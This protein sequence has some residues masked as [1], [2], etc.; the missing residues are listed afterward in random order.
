MPNS[1]RLKDWRKV[2][3]NFYIDPFEKDG[4][5][6]NTV[7]HL[8]QGSKFKEG[9]PE[10]YEQFSLG[11]GSVFSENPV[12]AKAAGGKTGTAKLPGESKRTRLRPKTVTADDS[13]W[14]QKNE[15]MKAAL[16]A[17][18]TQKG[19]PKNCS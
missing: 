1:L 15:I 6:W 4:K 14:G 13:F 19:L 18:F 12:L 9:N 17:K 8:Y 11:S 5:T 3:S 7:E 2:L 10:F 16:L